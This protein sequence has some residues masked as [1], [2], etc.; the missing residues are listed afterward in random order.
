MT[1]FQQSIAGSRQSGI[2]GYWFFRCA[3]V[4]LWPANSAI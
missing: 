2:N 1:V 4:F 3:L